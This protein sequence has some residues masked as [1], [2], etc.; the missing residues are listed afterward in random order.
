MSAQ[1]AGESCQILGKCIQSMNKQVNDQDS[2]IRYGKVSA[3]AVVDLARELQ[4]RNLVTHD[5]LVNIDPGLPS[6]ITQLMTAQ[7]MSHLANQFFS[8][9]HLLALWSLASE[10]T[11]DALLGLSIGQT[12]FRSAHGVLANWIRHCTTLGEA[13][14]TFASHIVLMNQSEHWTCLRHGA[15]EQSQLELRLNFDAAK[16]YPEIAWQRSMM[17]IPV[18]GEYFSGAKLDIEKVQLIFPEPAPHIR[19]KWETQFGCDVLFNQPHCSIWL[20]HKTYQT[21]SIYADVMIKKLVSEKAKAMLPQQ[22]TQIQTRVLDCIQQDPFT[23]SN[24]NCVAKE[25]GMSRST[26]YRKLKERGTEFSKLLEQYRYDIW[27]TNQNALVPESVESLCE[28]MGFQDASSLYKLQ[29]RW[30][31]DKSH[32]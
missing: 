17:I 26:L 30:Q 14:E 7:D 16:P 21:P 28:Q 13:F 11:D 27:Q 15:D 10:A 3:I 20:T 4:I 8:E 1:I 32:R 18:W 5:D 22:K 2:V 12:V 23:H 6:L 9:A 19:L 24:L 25:L 31:R 29:R